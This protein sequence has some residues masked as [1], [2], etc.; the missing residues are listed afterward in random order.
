MSRDKKA[1]IVFAVIATVFYVVSF[2]NFGDNRQKDTQSAASKV[3]QKTPEE[4]AKDLEIKRQAE[5]KY[6][7]ERERSRQIADED[8]KRRLEEERAAREAERA[9]NR[10]PV[11]DFN[12]IFLGKIT[13]FF[14]SVGYNA[15]ATMGEPTHYTYGQDETLTYPL[16]EDGAMVLIEGVR[17]G[18]V[19][20]IIVRA[21]E[22]NQETIFSTT[23]LYNAAIQTLAPNVNLDSVFVALNLN[24]NI[25]DDLSNTRTIVL[26]GYRFE[27]KLIGKTFELIAAE[28]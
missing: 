8:K 5:E 10:L 28:Q 13:I 15:Y 23:L 26:D 17:N 24:E 4:I 21:Y 25:L 27:K 11:A 18:G 6:A 14:Q 9:A 7:A 12:A 20:S 1:L 2:G 16:D 22:L 3:E 19:R